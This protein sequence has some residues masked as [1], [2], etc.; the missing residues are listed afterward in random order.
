[1][2]YEERIYEETMTI[3]KYSFQM[4]KI[5]DQPHSLFFLM[6]T[7]KYIIHELFF[8]RILYTHILHLH[9]TVCPICL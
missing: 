4:S 2:H 1:M 5:R 9:Y 3:A 8:K 6:K 7:L